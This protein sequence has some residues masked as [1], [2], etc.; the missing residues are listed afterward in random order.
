MAN[1]NT[2]TDEENKMELE[3]VDVE[4][5]EHVSFS[6][7]SYRENYGE[8]TMAQAKD[9]AERMIENIKKGD[10][11]QASKG[12]VNE[13]LEVATNARLSYFENEKVYANQWTNSC[14]NV[15]EAQLLE[16]QKSAAA[17]GAAAVEARAKHRKLSIPLIVVGTAAT[18]LSFL[19]AG[20]ACDPDD[21]DGGN[22]V[23]YTVAVLT[24]IVTVGSGIS[25]LYSFSNKMTE[26]I[27]ASGAFTNLARR[28]RTQLF[29]PN[30]LRSQAE[31][32]LV[33]FGAEHAHL[34]N[35][36]PLL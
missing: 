34:V 4:N 18:A 1:T 19:S 24:S 10:P 22:G 15:L 25:A 29:L 26:C 32:C 9:R 5:L 33:D 30:A 16:C 20:E 8:A 2:N 31:V 23:K 11:R 27:A 36:S 12:Y 35:T 6:N 28:I 21:G 7:P 17:Y 14:L 13:G 3:Q